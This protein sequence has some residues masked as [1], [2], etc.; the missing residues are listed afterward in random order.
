M[1]RAGF[2]LEI[3]GSKLLIGDYGFECEKGRW[4]NGRIDVD[5]L[6]DELVITFFHDDF[7]ALASRQIPDGRPLKVTR[8]DDGVTLDDDYAPLALV[9]PTQAVITAGHLRLQENFLAPGEHWSRVVASVGL[10]RRRRQA[11]RGPV[12]CTLRQFPPDLDP[13]LR[14]AALAASERI[15]EHRSI[16]YG[17]PVRLQAAELA[18]RFESLRREGRELRR[19]VHG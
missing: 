3:R 17:H 6:Y 9:R 5:G 7:V 8:T 18:L 12:E 14:D 4:A 2:E 11:P 19:A 15:R 13:D 16:V 10:P 1:K